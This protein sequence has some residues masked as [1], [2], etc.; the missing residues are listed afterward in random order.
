MILPPLRSRTSP[1][2][3]PVRPVPQRTALGVLSYA[4][5]ACPVLKTDADEGYYIITRYDDL[6]TVLEDP[7]TYS[8]VQAGLRGVPLPMPPLTEDPPRHIEYRAH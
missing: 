7:G 1:P 3:R 4:R 5:T 6:R 2:S 8:S